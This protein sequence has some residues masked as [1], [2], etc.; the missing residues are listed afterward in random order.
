MILDKKTIQKFNETLKKEGVFDLARVLR[1]KFSK[2]ELYLV[3]GS[4]RDIVLDRPVKDIDILIC[5]VKIKDLER[6][7]KKIGKVSLVGQRFSVLKFVPKNGKGY[8]D[9]A[10][11]RKDF[12]KGTGIYKDLKVKSDPNLP[13]ECDLERRDFTINTMAWNILKEE[14]VDP[15]GGMEDL[16]RKIIRTVGR[17]QERFREDY[18]RMLRAIRFAMQLNFK[19]E[20]RTRRAIKKHIGHIDDKIGKERKVPYEIISSEFLKA[21]DA[22][23]IKTIELY[24]D[25]GAM[26]KLMPEICAMKS[27]TQPKEFHSEGDVLTHTLLALKSLDSKM[28]KKYFS[29]PITLTTK[30]AILL[31]DVGKPKTKKKIQGK[32]KFRNHAQEGAKIAKKMLGRMKMSAPPE[33]GINVEE[34]AWLINN[35]LLF[36]HTDPEKM[37][38]TTFEKYLF[39]ERFS[40]EAHLWLFLADAMAT[41]P[42]GKNTDFTRF[43]KAYKL[44]KE[45]Q[46]E[47]K[48]KPPKSLLN[49]R[50]VMNILKIKSGPKVGEILELLREEQ[51]NKRIKNKN[52]AKIFLKKTPLVN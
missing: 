27:C 15:F 22:E 7:L 11:P 5:K 35:H 31:H 28:F 21:F 10:I 1:K 39:N 2:A 48:K 6:E 52:Q 34:A 33:V 9:I 29:Q 42:A 3:G 47:E 49:G 44:W 17:A 26:K 37:K 40:G 18:S 46:K 41:K 38:K 8:I 50:E 14:L 30:I 19:I 32:I 45:M 43:K 23:P 25:C 24:F 16:K 36:L 12:P 51:L 13:I 4:V 20:D